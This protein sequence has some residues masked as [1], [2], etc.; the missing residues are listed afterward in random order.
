MLLQ[1]PVKSKYGLSLATGAKWTT[2]GNVRIPALLERC[3]QLI[4]KQPMQTEIGNGA[5]KVFEFHGFGNVTV[6]S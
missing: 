2:K 6:Y 4:Q 5:D 1:I 3:R